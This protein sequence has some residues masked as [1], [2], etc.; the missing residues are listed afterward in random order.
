MRSLTFLDVDEAW[1]GE[2]GWP[3]ADADQDDGEIDLTDPA[4]DVD[5]DLVALHAVGPHLL[6]GLAAL[7]R[8]VITARY[9]LDGRA[10]QSMR[11]IQRALGV[12]REELRAALGDGLA[13]V[14]TRLR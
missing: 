6:D 2:D 1:L 11:E 12:P 7:E 14:R 4:A 8:A 3:Y 13:K 5:D 10:P 9:G